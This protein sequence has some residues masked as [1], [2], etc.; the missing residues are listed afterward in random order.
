MNKALSYLSEII[1][2]KLIS[3]TNS[4]VLESFNLALTQ[5]RMFAST[6]ILFKSSFN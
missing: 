6:L 2:S 3:S 5:A 4:I 1:T